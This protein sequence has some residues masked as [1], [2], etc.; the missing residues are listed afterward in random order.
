LTAERLAVPPQH[1]ATWPI[2][3]ARADLPQAR[4]WQTG[5]TLRLGSLGRLHPAKGYDVLIDALA[6]LRA[7]GFV[8]PVPFEIEVAGD[9]A[10]RLALCAQAARMGVEE[11]RFPGFADRPAD[12]LSGLHLYLQ[13]SR[14]EGLC[15]AA[16]E[17]MLAGLPVIASAVG[18]MPRSIISGVTGLVVPP[19]DPI[20]LARALKTLLTDPSALHLMGRAG[21]ERVLELFGEKAFATAGHAILDRIEALTRVAA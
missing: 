1:L 18:E 3:S 21:R 8:P 20:A 9:G 13:P 12:F 10:L 14:A 16:H 19:L 15:V 17:A 11:I 4:P 2:F 6:H 5:E 7:Q